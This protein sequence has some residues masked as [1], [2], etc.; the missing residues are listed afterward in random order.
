MT[1]LSLQQRV[2]RSRLGFLIL[3][4]IIAIGILSI[5]L[6]TV[7]PSLNFFL[8][9]ARRSQNETQATLLLQEGQEVAY[10]VFSTTP[11]W[12]VYTIGATYIPVHN[13][14]WE[15]IAGVEANL[16]TLYTRKIEIQAICRN[17]SSGEQMN[18]PSCSATHPQFDATSRLVVTTVSWE[19]NGT[20]QELT[21]EL[22]VTKQLLAP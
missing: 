20:S 16:E 17:P 1:V 11:N 14:M 10:H 18:I 21:A 6:V 22:L 15:L 2:R 7:F 5:V 9:R 19:E 12:D 3:E 13:G 8:K 4:A